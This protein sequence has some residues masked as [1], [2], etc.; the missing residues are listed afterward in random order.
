MGSGGGG[1]GG[2]GSSG[3]TLLL[4]VGYTY[5]PQGN[6]LSETVT[7][8]GQTPV[9][10]RFAY[11]D[12]GIAWADLDGNNNLLTR[13]FYMD[14]PDQLVARIEYTA[15]GGSGTG[16]VTAPAGA[17]TV[18]AAPAG[19]GGTGSGSTAAVGWYLTDKDGSVQVVTNAT[20]QAADQ[21]TYDAFGNITSETSPSAGDRYKFDGREFDSADALEYNRA[22]YYD[23]TTGRWISQDPLGFSAQDVNLYRYVGNQPTND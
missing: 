19:S 2:T 8:A 22:R 18:G 6:R 12:N 21:V 10:T 1:S 9:V 13:R 20:G 11:D 14:G 23:P 7:Q 15:Q 5:D 16:G 17:E 4:E 3:A